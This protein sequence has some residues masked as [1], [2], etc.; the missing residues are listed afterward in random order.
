MIAIKGL[1]MPASCHFCPF[2]YERQWRLYSCRATGEMLFDKESEEKSNK[3]VKEYIAMESGSFNSLI[4]TINKYYARDGWRVVSMVNR[5]GYFY[6]A[7]ERNKD[8]E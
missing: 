7:L 2:S 5:D 1:K 8:G 6:A 3:A 4:D